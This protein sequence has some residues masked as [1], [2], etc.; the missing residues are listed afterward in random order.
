VVPNNVVSPRLP[1][2]VLVVALLIVE[3]RIGF[4]QT[5]AHVAEVLFGQLVVQ[6]V[7]L[8]IIHAGRGFRSMG[9]PAFQADTGS[10][11]FD[12]LIHVMGSPDG[13]SN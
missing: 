7:K 4:S 2:D 8:P 9:A 3:F 10:P 6:F 1:V 13:G 12:G 5:S 11:A